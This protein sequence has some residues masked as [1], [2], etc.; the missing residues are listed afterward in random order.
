[1]SIFLNL[2]R[3]WILGCVLLAIFSPN[4]DGVMRSLGYNIGASLRF[5]LALIGVV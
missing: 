4:Q 1:M 3:A 2:L 5:V